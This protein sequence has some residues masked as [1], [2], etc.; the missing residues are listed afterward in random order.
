MDAFIDEALTLWK[1][2]PYLIIIFCCRSSEWV[3]DMR[4]HPA[5]WP[6]KTLTVLFMSANWTLVGTRGPVSI[7][8]IIYIYIYI[9]IYIGSISSLI[10]IWLNIIYIFCLHIFVNPF[11]LPYRSYDIR[12]KLVDK[13]SMISY[14]Q[15]TYC[16]TLGHHQWRMYYKND[17]TFVCT[18]H[19]VYIY[20]CRYIYRERSK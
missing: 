11:K 13:L 4:D 12:R 9:Y 18:L 6:Y 16:P 19:F 15:S 8:V 14:F 1:L 17:V 3:G 10:H 7:I 2:F 20:I 5:I